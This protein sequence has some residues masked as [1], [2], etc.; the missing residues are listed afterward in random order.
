MD[1]N[2]QQLGGNSDESQHAMLTPTDINA[3]TKACRYVQKQQSHY[4]NQF[5]ELLSIPSIST[6]PV[7]HADVQ[8]CAEWIIQAME[9]IGLEHCQI[10]PTAGQPVV[11]GDWLHAGNDRPTIVLYAHYDVQPVDPLELWHSPPFIPTIRDGKLFARGA[12]DDKSGVWVSLAA[13]DAMLQ[14]DGR[15]PVNVKVIWEGEEETGSPNMADFV[16][17]H[18]ELLAAD[19]LFICDGRFNPTQPDL[20][21]TLRGII[22]TEI[23]VHGPQ[24]DLHSGAYGGGVQNPAHVLAQIIASFHDADGR[25]QIPGFYDQVTQITDEERAFAQEMWAKEHE[26]WLEKAGVAQPWGEGLATLVERITALPSLDVNGL[27]SGY[28]DVGT[29]TIIPATASCKVTMRLVAQ[30]DPEQI[31]QRFSDHVL[32]FAT[33]T[34]HVE[35]DILTTILPF[36]T[37]REDPAILVAQR[38]LYSTLGKYALLMRAGGSVPIAGMFQHTLNMPAITF[39]LGSGTNVHSPNEYIVIA[40]F[41]KAIEAMIWLCHHANATI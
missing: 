38:A 24:R 19:M 9:E 7:Y 26:R 4:L 5:Q 17:A 11:Y 10:I 36:T 15:L 6:N 16:T 23:R 14:T 22:A 1:E 8:K 33:D 35:V 2:E 30:Q 39:G 13:L 20:A 27:T 31:A 29:K 40:D 3:A 32:G 12:V 18:Q 37:T 28:Q 41:Y 25:I 21:Y 34:A